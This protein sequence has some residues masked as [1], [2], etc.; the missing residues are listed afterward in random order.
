MKNGKCG[1]INQQAKIVIQL[2]FSNLKSFKNGKAYAEK[3]RFLGMGT[4]KGYI[5][6]HGEWLE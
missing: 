5:N 2:K 6:K 4:R 3:K 1:Y